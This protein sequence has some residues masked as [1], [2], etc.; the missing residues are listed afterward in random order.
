MRRWMGGLFT[1]GAHDGNEDV[2]DAERLSSFG[3][4]IGGEPGIFGVVC[5]VAK[6]E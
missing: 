3:L 6:S 1:Q 2:V 4:E 5:S